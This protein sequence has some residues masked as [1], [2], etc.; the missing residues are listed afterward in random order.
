M[1]RL[2]RPHLIKAE[3]PLGFVEVH[4]PAASRLPRCGVAIKITRFVL[5]NSNPTSCSGRFAESDVIGDHR[6]RSDRNSSWVDQ[7]EFEEN[8]L[9]APD[10]PKEILEYLDRQLFTGTAVVAETE[11]REASIV[12]DRLR[13]TFHHT[14]HRCR[15]HYWLPRHFGRL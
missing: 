11:R 13:L 7:I 5:F 8:D 10:L 14:E 15:N 9:V 2:S 1:R 12:A 3:Q 4:P 6:V